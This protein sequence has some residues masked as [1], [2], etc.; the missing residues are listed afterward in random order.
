M[1]PLLIAA[2]AAS[3][4]VKAYGQYKSAKDQ[5]AAARY[6]KMVSEQMAEM[7]DQSSALTEY[8]GR[9]QKDKFLGSQR[10]LYARSGVSSEGSPLEV[11]ADSAGQLELD[12]AVRKYNSQIQK[13]QALSEAN[14]YA[15]LQKTM[16]RQA[17]LSPLT[18]ILQSASSFGGVAG[19]GPT[20]TGGGVGTFIQT[21]SGGG[22]RHA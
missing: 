22:Y 5:E 15:R 14:N 12:I 2:L 9:R 17:I 11:M 3:T 10:A 18:T 1:G 6:N 21:S 4:A 19:G 8:Q 16:K 20:D 13:M 7:I